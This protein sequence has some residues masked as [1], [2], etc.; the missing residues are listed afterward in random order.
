MKALITRPET[1]A[2]PVADAL[3]ARGIEPVL[4]PMLRIEPIA[5]AATELVGALAG[6]Q[7][8]L[9]TSANGVRIYAE[10]TSRRELPAYCVGEASAAAARIA[11]FRAVYSADGDVDDLAALV[12]ARAAPGHGALLH[13]AG[14]ETAGDLAATLGAEGFT[15][16]RIVLYRAQPATALP[17]D[18][19]AALECGKIDIGLFFSPRTALTFVRLAHA[20]GIVESGRAMTALALSPK[21]A[22]ALDG[23]AWCAVVT[24]QAPNRRSLLAA[25][26]AMLA[27]RNPE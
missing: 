5:G 4:A 10:A 11:G 23:I 18:V 15:V 19:A 14:A 27:E 20:A 22:A 24:A 9:F 26:D 7:A 13:A 1:D 2:A 16:R 3:R 25:L 8:V 6:V 17:P 21:V 12:A